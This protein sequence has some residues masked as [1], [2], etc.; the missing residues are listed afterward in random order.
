MG[1]GGKG[2]CLLPPSD[3]VV[4]CERALPGEEL[5]AEITELGKGFA[6]AR[7]VGLHV[8][9]SLRIRYR[10]YRV[11]VTC[12]KFLLLPELDGM[13]YCQA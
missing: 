4:L 10:A 13:L 3:Y 1:F 12:C 2:V 5:V 7:K 9:H 6:A 8:C 11:T